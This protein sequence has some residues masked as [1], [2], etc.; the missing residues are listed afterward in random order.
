M[1][2]A[3]KVWLDSYEEDTYWKDYYRRNYPGEDWFYEIDG[4]CEDIRAVSDDQED[5]GN[6][7]ARRQRV[8]EAIYEV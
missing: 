7:V 6:D 1:G 3:N 4:D 8:A 5:L 2:I